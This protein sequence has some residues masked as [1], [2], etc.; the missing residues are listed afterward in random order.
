M[1]GS[2]DGPERQEEPASL[3]PLLAL[4][5]LAV[6]QPLLETVAAGPEFL[7]A[8]RRLGLEVVVLALGVVFLPPVALWLVERGVAL[9]FRRAAA[10]LHRAG[11]AAL[12]GCLALLVGRSLGLGGLGETGSVGGWAWLGTGLAGGVALAWL[13]A[14]RAGVRSFLRILALAALV[15]P[16]VFLLSPGVRT[17]LAGDAQGQ[18]AQERG[19]RPLSASATAPIVWIVFDEWALS[20]ILT[21]EGS[22]D[23]AAFPHLAAL[24]DDATWYRRAASV[25]GATELAVPAL[26]GGRLPAPEE[27]PVPSH[28]PVQLFSLVPGYEIWAQEVVSFLVPP[29]R[30]LAARDG[31][32][33]P[34]AGRSG[35]HAPGLVALLSDLRWLYLH[36]LVPDTLRHRLPPLSDRWRGFGQ[37][38]DSSYE[39][40]VT[41]RA[42]ILERF[43]PAFEE[44]LHADRGDAF[45]RF[46]GALGPED[47]RLYFLHLLL[48]HTPYRYLPDGRRYRL[49]TEHVPGLLG[50]RWGPSQARVDQARQ[51]YLAQARSLDVQIGRL[52]ARMKEVGLYERAALVVVSDHGISFRAGELRRTATA[53]NAHELLPVPLFVK[54]PGQTEGR[55]VDEPFSLA[56]LLPAALDAVDAADAPRRRASSQWPRG[57]LPLVNV[58]GLDWLDAD[59][60]DRVSEVVDERTRRFAGDGVPRFRAFE[61][62]VGRAVGEGADSLPLRERD[63][64]PPAVALDERLLPLGSS[65]PDRP[66]TALLRG[67]LLD[68]PP[69]ERYSEECC[70]LAIV[71]GGRVAATVPVEADLE[72]LFDVLLPLD[73]LPGVALPGVT[74]PGVRARPEIYRIVT[75]PAATGGVVLEHLPQRRESVPDAE[76]SDQNST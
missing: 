57:R 37:D 74:L 6:A 75:E 13:A 18:G 8:H 39:D 3:L 76:T 73:S 10:W 72:P 2:L 43:F 66:A 5:S 40:G 64:H 54:A 69:D 51:R 59:Q 36:R 45:D 70:D 32:D 22:L 24:A 68:V 26:L 67:R 53:E 29:E 17:L 58:S 31:S 52:V 15:V 56:D 60:L 44:R 71:L 41:E 7:V 14:T 19:L 1:T 28:W 16:A 49:A 34:R 30:N 42:A 33:D 20:T 55:V 65:G 61:G 62:L 35:I 21:P 23:A 48:P 46:L 12:G 9:R 27:L 50:E 4:W 38:H 25:S 63:P 47:R 11:I